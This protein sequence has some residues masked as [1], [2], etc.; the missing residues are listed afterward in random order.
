MT[1]VADEHLRKARESAA[2]DSFGGVIGRWIF[3]WIVVQ[4]LLWTTGFRTA[5]LIANVESGAAEVER[6]S[7]GEVGE[8]EIREAI[9]EQ[10]ES[11]RFWT[12]L[13]VVRDFVMGPAGLIVRAT[14]AAVA[15]AT[16]GALRG[17]TVGFGSGL[18]ATG[19]AQGFWVVGLVVQAALMIGLRRAEA[20]T[21]AVLLLPPGTYPAT[22]WIGLRELEV[23][24]LA[25]WVAMA[26]GAW[27]RGQVSLLGATVVVLALWLME[28][29][30][31][32]GSALV[33]GASMRRT[34]IP[35]I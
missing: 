19:Q 16:I 5:R 17:G 28:A 6:R 18:I 21:S 13:A 3:L 14:A 30:I 24:A 33:L 26:G 27:R 31:R 7:V 11:L 15:F 34:L 2:A 12:A 29:S 8:T 4:G 10:R 22:V 20:E 35:E 25:G 1:G 32:I 23:F 9:G